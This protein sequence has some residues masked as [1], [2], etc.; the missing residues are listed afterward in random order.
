M[1]PESEPQ[2]R[3]T[4]SMSTFSDPDGAG[5]PQTASSPQKSMEHSFPEFPDFTRGQVVYTAAV[6]FVGWSLAVYDL[7]TFGNMLPA[8][9]STF[10]WSTPTVTYIATFVSLG[11]LVFAV[12][13]G[14]LIDFLGRRAALLVTTGGAA[15]SSGLSALAF[16]PVSLVLFRTLSGLG[17]SEQAVNSAYLNEVFKPRHKGFLYGIVQAG[18]PFGVMISAGL[19]VAIEPSIGWRAVFL[20]GTFPLLIMLL[21]RTR[22]K[23]S[24]Y[25]R[26]VQYVRKL[27]A[28]GDSEAAEAAARHWS[29]DM[30]RDRRN[31][32]AQLFAP[33]LRKH[34]ISVGS[35]FFFKLIADSVLTNLATIV[36]IHGKGLNLTSALWTVF[37]A[38]AVAFVGFLVFGAVGD[39]IGRR[40]TALGCEILSALPAL[41]LLTVAH[42]FVAVIVSYSL[43]LFLAQGAA[44][45]LFAYVGESYPTRIRGTGVAFI[46]ITGPIGSVVG[47][48]LYGI[49][50]SAGLNADQAALAS[51][52][53]SVV[54]GL[55]LLG[56]RRIR[57]QQELI[58][59]SH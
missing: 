50:Q 38:N 53:A 15:L 30:R 13:V 27:R 29:L 58:D 45:A 20:V 9:Q 54:A 37:V 28:S 44:S 31:T 25:F 51:V 46:G 3:D 4:T 57:P 22:L 18:W 40:E 10:G 23:E 41:F 55:C 35:M 7:I 34:T 33:G 43:M 21:L 19:A 26:K 11:S 32:Y 14:P 59:V 47:P 1:P 49:L 39:K 6:A 52:A 24:P 16:G 8:I 17:L 36:L 48:L 2:K 5:P 42:S 56:A 12:S